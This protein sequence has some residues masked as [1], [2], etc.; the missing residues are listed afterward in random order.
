M[1]NSGPWLLIAGWG[2]VA[3]AF[4]G[5]MV[6]SDSLPAGLCWAVMTGISLLVVYRLNVIKN[7]PMPAAGTEAPE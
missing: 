7:T 6:T 2:G 1:E 3:L 5:M 4:F